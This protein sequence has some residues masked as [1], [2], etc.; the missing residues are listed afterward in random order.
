MMVGGDVGKVRH[1]ARSRIL[2]WVPAVVFKE[3]ELLCRANV[4]AGS[5]GD[6]TF[7]AT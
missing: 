6:C 3:G 4:K 5:D 2:M 7:L 1:G